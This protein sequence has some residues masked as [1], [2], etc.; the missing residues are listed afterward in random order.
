MGQVSPHLAKT[1]KDK[2][3]WMSWTAISLLV[4][5]LLVAVGVISNG[6]K[7][8][9]AE[10]ALVLFE[11]ASN[12][13]IALI[14][15]IVATASIQSSSTVTSVIVGLVAGGMPL[16]IAIPM[17]MGANIGTSLTSTLVSLG[18]IQN[19]AEFKRAF[20]AATVHDCFNFLA[21][22][23]IL[24][25]ELLFQPLEK[26]A[27]YFA[28]FFRSGSATDISSFNLLDASTKPLVNGIEW[29]F[30]ILPDMWD[31]VLM[32]IFGIFLILLVIRNIG[33]LLKR[34]MVGRSLEII[35]N[36]IGR[37]P[38]SGIFAGS[39]VTVMVQSSSTT[40][41]LIVPMAG[42]GVFSIQQVYPFTLGGNL[43]TTV[44]AAIAS[45]T[46]TG[47]MA[48]LSFQIALVHFFFNL[49][50]IL[51]IYCI[52]LLR[53]IPVYMSEKMAA[54]SQKNKFF[55]M[56]YILGVFFITPLLLIWLAR[57]F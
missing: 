54:M 53:N 42:S 22:L 56:G 43:G 44:T 17:I 23:V 5:L 25:I 36:T 32:I 4:Y 2:P 57:M 49:F 33:K 24:P 39:V 50:G 8:A 19:G 26:L 45:M 51:L 11:F 46:F 41:A 38:I 7:L 52:P 37:D 15:G 40:T 31:G 48:V 3:R 13:L 21:V 27:G 14:I 28:T 16:G 18:H 30:A 47:P 6:F 29:V 12:P 55:V 35:Q 34:L 20:S 1:L 10:H 9:T